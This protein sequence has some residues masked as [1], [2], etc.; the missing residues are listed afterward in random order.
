MLLRVF[1]KCKAINLNKCIGKTTLNALKPNHATV[2]ECGDNSKCNIH[3]EKYSDPCGYETVIEYNFVQCSLQYL[4]AFITFLW[5]IQL[6]G[7]FGCRSPNNSNNPITNW[8]SI[9]GLIR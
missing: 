7:C 1:D 4:T 6:Y 5:W 3:D 8:I 9:V 2:D